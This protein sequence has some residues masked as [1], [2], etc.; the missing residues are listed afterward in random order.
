MVNINQ[1]VY[2]LETSG[3]Y[4]YMLPFLLVFI[5]IFSILEKVHILGS[6]KAPITPGAPG[7]SDAP[8]T[9]LNAIF[10]VIVSLIVI[11]NTDIVMLI[12]N[13]MSKMAM[14]VILTVMFMI[15]VA[16]ITGKKFDKGGF[17]FAALFALA[18]AVWSL[19][20]YQLHNQA[21]YHALSPT[22]NASFPLVLFGLVIVWIV[23]A[24]STTPGR[25]TRT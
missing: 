17:F 11:V 10:S 19:T 24:S 4:E 1:L 2:Q 12:N 9:S 3:V 21:W 14:I 18:A 15:L 16:L 23:K 7:A 8:K 5:V 6:I 20:P 25:W 13:Y 22:I